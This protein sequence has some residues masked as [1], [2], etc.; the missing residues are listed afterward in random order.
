VG[1]REE[2][3]FDRASIR[4]VAREV[5]ELLGR[6]DGALLTARQVATRFNVDRSWV[7]AHADELGV[8]RLGQGPRPRLR[9]DPAVVAQRVVAARGRSLT[10]EPSTPLRA[11]ASLLPIRPSRRRRTL[12]PGG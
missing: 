10:P 3:A 6:S 2:P 1:V 12:D 5:A 4:A 11:G 8:V 9:F 7:Y